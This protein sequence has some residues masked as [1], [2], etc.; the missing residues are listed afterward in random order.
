MA[1]GGIEKRY[2]RH[3][4]MRPCV[5]KR[6]DIFALGDIIIEGFSK[7]EVERYFRISTTVGQ[8]RVF[9]NSIEHLL[10]QKELG[11][12]TS[13]LSFWI[14]GWEQKTRFDKNILLD[15]SKYSI[16]LNVEG[17]DPVWVYD[18]YNRIAKFLRS[19]TA[20]F[21]PIIIMEK[22]IIF[23]ITIALITNIIIAVKKGNPAYYLDKLGLL[24]VWMFL[25]FYDTRKLWPYAN[26]IV[27]EEPNFLTKANVVMLAMIL[28]VIMA[29][30][31]GTIL[32]LMR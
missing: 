9:S 27:T 6:E 1:A 21:W 10:S 16:Q 31:G 13:D 26:I 17:T 12:Q 19:K 2:E 22:I 3:G 4:R 32:P 24:S 23:L 15:F 30:A 14:E 11:D 28:V 5:L 29:I 18:K 7:P 20:W 8:T 25:V